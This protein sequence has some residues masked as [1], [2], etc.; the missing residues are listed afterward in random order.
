MKIEYLTD[1]SESCPVVR[2]FNFE[3][4]EIEELRAACRA[5][6]NG[7]IDRFRLDS[8]PS[9]QQLGECQMTFEAG[10]CDRGLVVVSPP[11]SL[12]WTLSRGTWD[13]IEGLL[14]PFEVEGDHGYQW[15]D[16]RGDAKVLISRDGRW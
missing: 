1:G 16:S 9:V 12:K 3:P 7:A 11:A 5:L 6:H 10:A 2:L 14:E 4:S 13:N 8:I 15:L